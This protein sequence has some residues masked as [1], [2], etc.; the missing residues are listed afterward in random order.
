MFTCLADMMSEGS[1]AEL[2]WIG[3]HVGI[4]P[5]QKEDIL[6]KL[7]F[8]ADHK[9]DRSR[10]N[11]ERVK[12]F[13]KGIGRHVADALRGVQRDRKTCGRCFERKSIPGTLRNT[14][15]YIHICLLVHSLK[16]LFLIRFYT[17]RTRLKFVENYGLFIVH[18]WYRGGHLENVFIEYI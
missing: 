18:L 12:D 8:T 16:K 1:T 10:S 3:G 5:N 6:P 14:L 15:L 4:V 17:F 11:R 2:Y 13:F 9:F 7:A